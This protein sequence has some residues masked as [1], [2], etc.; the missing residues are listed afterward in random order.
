[1]N[2]VEDKKINKQQEESERE[3]QQVM[4]SMVDMND[5]MRMSPK[6]IKKAFEINR[7]EFLF[8]NIWATFSY[9]EGFIPR[10]GEERVPFKELIAADFYELEYPP[11]HLYVYRNNLTAIWYVPEYYLI[12]EL[13]EEE[14]K[15]VIENIRK[16]LEKLETCSLEELSG[17]GCVYEMDKDTYYLHYRRQE[18]ERLLLEK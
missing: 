5:M 13:K 17:C 8:E 15:R 6:F 14:S 3:W 2:K 1:M 10:D 4:D 16:Q 18:F 7:A 9:K 12:N 11:C